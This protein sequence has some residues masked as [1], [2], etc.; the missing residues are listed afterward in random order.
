MLKVAVHPEEKR[1]NLLMAWWNGRGAARVLE[2]AGDAVLIERAEETISLA[3]LSRQ[4]R[5]DEVSRI[6][7]A[8]VGRLHAPGS[9]P[10]WHLLDELIPLTRWFEALAPAADA[11]GGILRRAA[12]AASGLLAT[13]RDVMVLHGDI[14]HRNILDFGPRGW[15]AIDPKGLHGERGFDYA[16]LF[17][18][19]D[20]E[21]ATARLAP[22]V[23]VVAEAAALDRERLLQWILAWAGLAAAFQIEDGISPKGALAIAEL[24][25]AEL[26]R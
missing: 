19:P 10:P 25:A 17:C 14:H 1:G 15:L 20:Q 18:N 13:P 9:L 12:V 8:T 22:R 5:D 26:R 11:H 21:T 16:N 23:E 2:H 7:C 4:G 3:D 24:A 6:I